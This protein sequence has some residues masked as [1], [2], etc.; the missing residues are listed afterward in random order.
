[1]NTLVDNKRYKNYICTHVVYI[2]FMALFL[3]AF[4]KDHNENAKELTIWSYVYCFI[5]GFKSQ[6]LIGSLLFCLRLTEAYFR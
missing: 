3:Y 1:M 4:K 6:L 5:L 2:F